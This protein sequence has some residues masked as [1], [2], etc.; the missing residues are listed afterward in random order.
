MTN[1]VNEELDRAR[2]VL[3]AAGCDFALLSSLANVTYVSGFEV[4]VPLGA[5]A[6]CWRNFSRSI[7][8]IVS[9]QPTPGLHFWK[10]SALRCAARVS[11]IRRQH[12]GSR[13]GPCPMP[14]ALCWLRS[15][16]T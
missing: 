2:T 15:F 12:L 8:L 7:R 9:T 10:W 1:N 6:Q 4:P 5:T 16:P 13:R 3:K 11:P 14:S